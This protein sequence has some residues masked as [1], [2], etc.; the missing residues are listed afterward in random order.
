MALEAALAPST[1][2]VAVDPGKA[3]HRVWLSKGSGL[4]VDPVTMP[5][6]LRGI[7]SLEPLV[8]AHQARQTW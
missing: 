5:V 3:A 7:A 2:V 6:S 4:L 8:A 1:L